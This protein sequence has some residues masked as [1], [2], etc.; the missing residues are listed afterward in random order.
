[1]AH[2]DPKPGPVIRYDYL[3]SHEAAAGRDQDKERPACLVAARDSQVRPRPEVRNA[4]SCETRWVAYLPCYPATAFTSSRSP[5]ASKAASIWSMREAWLRSSRRSTC[6]A[7]Q[8]R[9]RASSALETL[10]RRMAR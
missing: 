1:M 8:C 7:W 6:G 2:P 10:S 4:G 5:S 9:R 3:W